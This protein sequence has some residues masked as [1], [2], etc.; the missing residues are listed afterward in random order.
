MTDLTGRV[1][2]V[3]GGSSGIGQ[4][5]VRKLNALGAHVLSGDL[6]PFPEP[7]DRVTGVVADLSTAEGCATLVERAKEL[8]GRLDVIVNNVGIAPTRGGFEAIT[9]D[10]WSLLWNVNLM[11]AV[12]VTRAGIPLL[13]ESYCGSIV[14]ISSSTARVVDPYWIDYAATKAGLLAITRGLAEEL[15][16]DGIRVNAV[17]PGSIRTPLWDVPGGFSEQLAI[18]YD[19]DVETAIGR[20]VRDER[21]IT[22]GRPGSAEDVA[23]TVAFLVS[24]ESSY[25]TGS[26]FPVNGGSVKHI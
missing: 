25:I 2:I 18:R 3:T 26:D 5:T 11:S 20:Y 17:S 7:L 9:D 24:D 14:M 6:T 12:R 22:L 10:D 16:A 8:H 1:A 21:R 23:N 15:G 4:A 13:R 19:T